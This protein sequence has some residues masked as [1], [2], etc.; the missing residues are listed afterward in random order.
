[1]LHSSPIFPEIHN[2]LQV[3]YGAQLQMYFEGQFCPLYNVLKLFDKTLMKGFHSILLD[4][5]LYNKKLNSI[6]IVTLVRVYIWTFPLSV[7][8]RHEHHHTLFPYSGLIRVEPRYPETSPFPLLCWQSPSSPHLLFSLSHNLLSILQ[9]TVLL[10]LVLPVLVN[11][12][13]ILIFIC[14]K[15]IPFPLSL[16]VLWFQV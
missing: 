4:S 2:S 6:Y 13:I 3:L 14:E 11:P 10:S 9:T 8:Y 12:R 1:M 7:L 5:K 16:D 15:K